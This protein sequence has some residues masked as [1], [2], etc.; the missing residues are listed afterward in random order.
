MAI[1]ASVWKEWLNY[2]TYN[3]T[4]FL[5]CV[6]VHAYSCF[7]C[8]LLTCYSLLNTYNSCA[9][10][11]MLNLVSHVKKR[12]ITIATLVLFLSYVSFH[13]DSRLPFVQMTFYSSY[14][15]TVFLL[16]VSFHADSCF[17]W[18]EMTCYSSYIGTVFLLYVSFHADFWCI[19]D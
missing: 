4:V 9:C 11:Y 10:H 5:I 12:L 13:A 8:D 14:I 18:D 17:P 15:G 6:S 16:Y 3:G 1:P 19:F 2:S 7:L